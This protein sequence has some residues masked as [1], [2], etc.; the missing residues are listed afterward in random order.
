MP[1]IIWVL[2]PIAHSGNCRTGSLFVISQK[3]KVYG[4]QVT[5]KSLTEDVG[6]HDGFLK[7]SRSVDMLAPFLTNSN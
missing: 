2:R 4:K 6:S 1:L 7:Y 5:K 3:K